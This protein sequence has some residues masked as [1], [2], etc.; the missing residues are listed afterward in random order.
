MAVSNSITGKVTAVDSGIGL[1]DLIVEAYNAPPAG[2]PGS[3]PVRIGS[4]VTK[5]DGSFVLECTSSTPSIGH[6]LYITVLSPDNS[7]KPPVLLYKSS[8]RTNAS[9]QESFLVKL[10]K[11]KLTDASV[12]V[13][14]DQTSAVDILAKYSSEKEANATL[15]KGITAIHQKEIIDETTEKVNFVSDFKTALLKKIIS[16]NPKDN[17]VKENASIEEVH[18][19]IVTNNIDKFNR[20]LH[21]TS[22]IDQDNP[23]SGMQVWFYL[24]ENDKSKLAAFKHDNYYHFN[25][26]DINDKPDIKEIVA[27][28]ISNEGGSTVLNYDNPILKYFRTKGIHEDCA[29]EHL[30]DSAPADPSS[31]GPIVA[32]GDGVEIVTSGDMP[33]YIARLIN[34]MPSPEDGITLGKTDINTRPGKSEVQDSVN[35][36]QLQKGP[37][38]T[39]ATYDFNVLQ[40]AFDHVWHQLFDSE[41]I[42]LLHKS[43]QAATNK[44]IDIPKLKSDLPSISVTE[45]KRSIEAIQSK[46]AVPPSKVIA[47]FEIFPNEWN[48]LNADYKNKLG[49]IADAIEL[50]LLGFRKKTSTPVTR[51]G[52]FSQNSNNGS[53]EPIDFYQAERYILKLKEQGERIIDIVRHDDYD[54]MDKVLQELENKIMSHYVF[55][56]YAAD[57]SYSTINF[58]LLNTY[59]QSW[60]PLAY[61]VGHLIKTIPLAP[62]E[63]RK[64]T[65]KTTINRKRSEKEEIKNSASE[66][67]ESTTTV[68]SES[69]IM[70]KVNL[71]FTADAEFSGWSSFKTGF[72]A[73][74]ESQ[75][76]KK[77]IRDTVKKAVEEHKSERNREVSTEQ[78]YSRDSEE[79][80]T[81]SNPNDELAVTYLF[82][83]LQKRYKISEQLYRVLPVVMVA[84]Q[85][86]K[87]E[88]ITESW[89][90]S[91]DWI[92][93]R[94]LL[95]KSF[96]AGL[97]YLAHHSMKDELAL[98]ELKKNLTKERQIVDNLSLEVSALKGEVQ[99][100]YVA[101][102]NS[103]NNRIAANAAP[104]VYY[105]YGINRPEGDTTPLSPEAAK[106]YEEA[107]RQ[108]HEDSVKRSAAATKA[109]LTETSALHKLTDNYN[110]ALTH[111]LEK[112]KMAERFI[113][114]IKNNI[115]HYMRAIWKHEDREQ[116]YF[117]LIDVQVPYLETDD[118]SYTITTREEPEDIFQQ[119]REANETKHRSW[120]K[121]KFKPPT[122]KPLVE[123]AD[124]DHPLGFKGNYMIF[125]M[126]EHNALTQ[127]MSAPYVDAAFGAMDPDSLSNIGLQDYSGF[128]CALHNDN[129]VEFERLRPTL[130]KW[131]E[132]LLA[133]PMRDGDEIVVP[134]NSLVIEALP[135]SHTL[136]EDF[137]LRHR[138]MD[139]MKVE[140]EVRKMELEN[141]RY[142]ARLLNAEHE[143]PD[144]DKNIVVN[145]NNAGVTLSTD[146]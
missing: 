113:L 17:F 1:P 77:E 36:F 120:I 72:E 89:I 51:P 84:Q 27:R 61:Q 88:E 90:I 146:Q 127:F 82:Y 50:A 25:E 132:I 34:K 39:T 48:N 144:V 45:L 143:D 66:S 59:R 125:P 94:N 73:D 60:E 19:N 95:D 57:A 129:P 13:P 35:T 70:K 5:D 21:W 53:F 131:L 8:V 103:I 64:F 108:A 83:E 123:V 81:I 111:F 18:K 14:S 110:K 112:K 69:E 141:I 101:L 28:L 29:K 11:D 41:V 4:V 145:G 137:K 98:K 49:E 65:I 117:R 42:D 12:P 115:F 75:R 79:T 118:R 58:G 130:K 114:H 99:N 7:S 136:L 119:F 40:I 10:S 121:G 63:E 128:V 9:S 105:E 52:P 93:R 133:D 142:A 6:G 22:T 86:P 31:T 85:V 2:L 126:N 87:P 140:A 33:K 15:T 26:A 46:D 37:A 96:L 106:A 107:A 74:K 43:Y 92:L 24:S 91:Y 102:E 139:V 32:A 23:E 100:R 38:E 124:L 104:P 122:Y 54:S 68:H 16:P 116:R 47:N 138:A 80:G 56:V 20:S 3:E 67:S 134:G 135:A 44:G 30:V 76:N 78:S 55:K 71:K 97:N 109:L 62:K